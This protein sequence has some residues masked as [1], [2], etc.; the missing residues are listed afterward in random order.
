MVSFPRCRLRRSASIGTEDN[1]ILKEIL[2]MP[3]V[4]LVK[5]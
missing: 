5:G 3:L 2:F 1:P 4:S